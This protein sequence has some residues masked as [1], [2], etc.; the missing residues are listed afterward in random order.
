MLHIKKGHVI[1][2][3]NNFE[4]MD[5][6]KNYKQKIS[7]CSLVLDLF[8]IFLFHPYLH[9]FS[10]FLSVS[11]YFSHTSKRPTVEKSGNK[12]SGIERWCD[13]RWADKGL[14]TSNV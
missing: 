4:I 9:V 12:R 3:Y 7:D 11:V 1:E 2:A 6:G 10:W 5:W 8:T 14:L 13:M